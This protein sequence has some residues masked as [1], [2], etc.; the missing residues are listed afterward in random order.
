MNTIKFNDLEKCIS[1]YLQC[2]HNSSLNEYNPSWEFIQFNYNGECSDNHNLYISLE[3][4][5]S[6]N[7]KYKKTDLYCKDKAFHV[8]FS[9][10]S[11][12]INESKIEGT[13]FSLSKIIDALFKDYTKNKFKSEYFYKQR[14]G[15]CTCC[16]NHKLSST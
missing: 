1:R 16:D 15:D 8:Y 2:D 12:H 10:V 13:N 5:I 7:D 6:H 14:D 4:D 3:E 11:F 9:K